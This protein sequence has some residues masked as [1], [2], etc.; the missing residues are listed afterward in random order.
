LGEPG[1]GKTR[2]AQEV[3]QA[4]LDRRFLVATGRCYEPQAAVGYYPFLEALTH[5]YAAVPAAVRAELS[6]RWVEV[7][8]LL[9][10]QYVSAPGSVTATTAAASGHGDQQRLVW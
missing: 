1:T 2:L 10:D 8:C 4:A 7:A 9:P 6:Q 5:V 3:M